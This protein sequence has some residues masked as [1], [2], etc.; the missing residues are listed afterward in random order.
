MDYGC[1]SDSSVW[2]CAFGSCLVYDKVTYSF[3]T[4]TSG[5]TVIVEVVEGDDP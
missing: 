1:T 4:S 5:E 2:F 3:D